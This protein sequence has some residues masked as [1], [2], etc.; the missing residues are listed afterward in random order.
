MV[1]ELHLLSSLDSRG[2]M[3]DFSHD[4]R[5]IVD[6]MFETSVPEKSLET[7]LVPDS[8]NGPRFDG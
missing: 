3:E 2:I 7:M 6:G 5:H 8:E 1:G 4:Q